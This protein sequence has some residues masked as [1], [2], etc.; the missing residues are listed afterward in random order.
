MSHFSSIR[1]TIKSVESLTLA[2]S[3]LGFKQVE[4]HRAP[5]H[6]Y[7]FLGD[8]RPETAEVIIRRKH[9]G[10]GSN[11]IGFRRSRD[12]TFIAIISECDRHSG[13]GE[14]W[15]N[16][17]L[18]RYAY[19]ATKSRIESQGFALSEETEQAGHLHLTWRRLC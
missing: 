10:P 17:L 4:V 2:L 5:H 7:G 12:G 6:L 13:F 19:H 8:Q 15:V 1:T 14:A 18:Q 9:V 16:K 3:D 11:D